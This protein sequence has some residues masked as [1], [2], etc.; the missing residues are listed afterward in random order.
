MGA[1]Q[2]VQVVIAMRQPYGRIYSGNGEE[3]F[4]YPLHGKQRV[5]VPRLLAE[6]ILSRNTYQYTASQLWVCDNGV[7]RPCG[8]TTLRADAQ[9]LLGQRTAGAA[10]V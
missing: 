2:A 9:A 4:D 3:F 6:A 5:F 8:E 1:W 10:P 7:Y